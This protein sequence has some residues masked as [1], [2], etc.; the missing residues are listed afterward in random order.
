MYFIGMILFICFALGVI[1]DNIM[2]CL[3]AMGLIIM[4]IV[5]EVI[6]DYEKGKH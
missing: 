2:I 5:S 3:F 6:K 1:V 4:L